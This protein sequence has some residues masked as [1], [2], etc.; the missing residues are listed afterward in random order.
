MSYAFRVCKRNGTL[1]IPDGQQ[2][3]QIALQ[4][5]D[6]AIFSINGHTPGPDT[7]PVGMVGV[8]LVTA[9][10]DGGLQTFVGSAQGSYSI[11]TEG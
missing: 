7:S 8:T 2:L 1:V 10:D 6:G 4:I 11:S 5:P 9:P 3:E